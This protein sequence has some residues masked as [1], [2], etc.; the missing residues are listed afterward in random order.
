M[1]IDGF[2]IIFEQKDLL[3]LHFLASDP[4]TEEAKER[5]RGGDAQ[6]LAY[7]SWI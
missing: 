2:S 5:R 3:G 4:C 1:D 7:G 6:G